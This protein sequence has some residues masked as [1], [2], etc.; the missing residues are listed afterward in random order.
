[1]RI[2]FICLSQPNGPVDGGAILDNRILESLTSKK[3]EI[4]PIYVPRKK[5][6]LALP[7]W[8]NHI[9]KNIINEILKKRKD[10][11]KVI[12]SHESLFDLSDVIDVDCLLVHNYF[13]AFK[14]KNFKLLEIYY[15]L[16]SR[17]FYERAYNS[18]K[19]VFFISH[20]E[21]RIACTEHFGLERVSDICIPPP[22][23]SN[24]SARSNDVIH[25]SGSEGWFPKRIC[26]LKAH[27]VRKIKEYG[28][29]VSD[30]E[31]NVRPANALITDQFE[32]GFKLKLSQMLHS[33][34]VI[35]SLSDLSDEINKLCFGHPFYKYVRSVDEALG[36]F[37]TIRKQYTDE[38]IDE[39]YSNLEARDYLPSWD[40]F[41]D[42]LLDLISTN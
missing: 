39:V 7:F 12:I 2:L 9:P 37:D 18:A 20:R 38:E 25:L 4:I 40:K 30:L 5:R 13:S 8:K 29:H 16:G 35:A 34:D 26:K 28:Y 42:R 27:Q 15:R 32:V 10:N 24:R 33:R 3:I 31:R 6:A 23:N 14:F 41:T 36:F 17:K 21:Y 22:N 11:T 1:M 19:S